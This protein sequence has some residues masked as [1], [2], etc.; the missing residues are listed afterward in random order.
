MSV[1]VFLWRQLF[2]L[3]V[4]KKTSLDVSDPEFDVN[5]VYFRLILKSIH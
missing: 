3:S 2:D 1:G 5:R 4:S